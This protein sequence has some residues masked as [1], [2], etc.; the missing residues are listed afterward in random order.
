VQTKVASVAPE[1]SED[2]RTRAGLSPGTSLP[3]DRSAQERVAQLIDAG[4]IDFSELCASAGDSSAVLSVAALCADPAYLS[5]ALDSIGD[6]ERLASLALDGSPS[7]VRQL[8]A[9]R[10]E[11]PAKLKHLLKQVREKDKSVYKILKQ[12]CDV[13]RAEERRIAQIEDDVIA[14]CASLERHAQRIYDAIYEPSFRHFNARWE[15]LEAQAVPEIR[16][17]AHRAIE[18]CRGV[19]A[20]HLRQLADQAAEETNRAARE[21]ARQE[22]LAQA[23]A[24][25]LRRNEAAALAAAEA[26]AIREA[27]EKARAER[28][29]A[30]ALL[31][32]QIGGLIAKAHGELRDGNTGRAAGL[33]RAIEEKQQSAAAMP[34]HLARQVQQ[35]DAK[36]NELKEWKDYAVA[37][38]RLELIEQMEALI[39]SS[40]APKAVA[41]RIKVLQEEWRTISRGVLSDSEADWQRFHQASESA[42]QPCREYFD[43]QAKMRR[44][45][46]EKRK[47]VLQ[48]FLAF[49]A[50]QSGEKPDWHA[51]AAVLREARQEWRGHFPVDREAGV[52]LQEQ[53]DAAVSRLQAR[54]DAWHAQNVADKKSLIQRAQA[55]RAKEDGREAV[56]A[57]KHLQLKWNEV[58]AVPR[59]QE[60]PLWNEFREQCDAIFQRRQQA[61]AEHTAGLEANRRQAAAICEEAEQVAALSGPALLE[62][63]GKIPQ[64]R[65]ALEALG[66]LPRADE[67]ALRE[68][69]DRAI[70]QCQAQLAQQRARDKERSYT[71]LFEAGR[72]IQAFGWAVAQG[73][74]AADREELK[75]AAEKYI[76]EV[77]QWP[78]G[79]AQALKEAL[80][81]AESA[82]AHEAASHETELR[83]LCIR[84]EIL[85]EAAT[86][87]EDQ[88]LR[89]EYQVQRLVQRMGHGSEPG[90]DELDAL[91]LEWIR[92]GPAPASAHQSLFERFLRCRTEFAARARTRAGAP[93]SER[94][95]RAPRPPRR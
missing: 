88:P 83:M 46:L 59:D 61:Y 7:R 23:Q 26:N 36:L 91:A 90:A 31:L 78:K 66:E 27:E 16:D 49:E 17:R 75:Q 28:L 92:V 8:A 87:P 29:A 68:R 22:A 21:A 52:A 12:K 63:I 45:N 20:G 3:G 53:F 58:G 82:A 80:L 25:T 5:Q 24:E 18:R 42:Y 76:A 85:T 67:R 95:G 44:A 14:A 47:E 40:E 57:V 71:H 51:V 48:R 86:P 84:N 79:G 6:P 41:E 50:A 30:E 64:W 37:P 55:L 74:A 60:Q 33:R 89:R 73:A 2:L 69:F 10:I 34:P 62:G 38:K 9:Q 4:A 93:I 19:I 54:L 77:Q 43:A 1:T 13:L 70:D 11:D 65:A 39:G 81:K 94:S 72:R 15:T 35:L 56:D 32:R